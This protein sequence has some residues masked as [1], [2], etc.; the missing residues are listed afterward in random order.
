MS[1][2]PAAA[3]AR[4]TGVHGSDWCCLAL[5]GADWRCMLL[6]LL[7]PLSPPTTEELDC[8]RTAWLNI[9]RPF[10]AH[11]GIYAMLFVS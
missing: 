11:R 6:M 10:L 1:V 4:F 9:I 8:L 2:L 7:L 3:T 5:A